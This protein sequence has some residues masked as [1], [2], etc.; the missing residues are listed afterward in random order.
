[1]KLVFLSGNIGSMASPGKI[2]HPQTPHTSGTFDI[3]AG[4]P[5]QGLNLAFVD[6]VVLDL[7]K[8]RFSADEEIVIRW[9]PYE[10]AQEYK[11]QIFASTDA[12][13]YGP[14]EAVFP[15][16][17]CPVVKEPQ[18]NLADYGV[19]LKDGHYYTV[20][21]EARADAWRPISKTPIQH[22]GFQFQIVD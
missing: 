3:A 19:V 21:V 13:A 18:I 22:D 10:G 6:P 14:S 8:N 16:D 4:A 2:G 1:M 17:E 9:H 12:R 20:H 5:G 7:S 15:W 11:V